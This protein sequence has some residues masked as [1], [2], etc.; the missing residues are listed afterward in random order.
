MK[1]G[2]CLI[3]VSTMIAA[4]ALLSFAGQ[5]SGTSG[6]ESTGYHMKVVSRSTQSVDYRHKGS[7]KVDFKG[8]DLMPKIDGEAKVEGRPG[9]VKLEVSLDHLQ[10]A[11][12]LGLSYLTYVLWAITPEGQAHNLGEMVVKDGESS[13]HTTTDLQAFALVLTAEPDFAVAEPSELVG[14]GT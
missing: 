7:T 14:L 9:G 6:T 2:M 12:N 5:T 4:S 10:P 8:T 1:F 13:L 11:N 3:A